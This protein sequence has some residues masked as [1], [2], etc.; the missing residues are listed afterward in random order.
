MLGEL[1]I[2]LMRH[3][4]AADGAGYEALA[5]LTEFGALEIVDFVPDAIGGG[6]DENE[7]IAPFGQHVAARRPRDG[8]GAQP[9]PRQKARLYFERPGAE[10]REAP[11]TTAELSDIHPRRDFRKTLYVAINL[12]NP[13]GYLETESDRQSLLPMGASRH[14]RIAVAFR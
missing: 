9:E 14:D 2:A 10:R 12:G 6:R 13:S 11:N 1:R 7:Q 4:D 5:H 8:R 3:C